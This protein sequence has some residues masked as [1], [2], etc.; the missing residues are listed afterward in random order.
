VEARLQ[1]LVHQI[2]RGETRKVGDKRKEEIESANCAKKLGV[3]L[4]LSDTM[5]PVS[6]EIYLSRVCL[7]GWSTAS[8]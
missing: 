2:L 1:F 6:K 3:L 8:S 4:M 5:L 7:R